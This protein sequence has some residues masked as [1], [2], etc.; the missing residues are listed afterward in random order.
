MSNTIDEGGYGT[1]FYLGKVLSVELAPE[2]AAASDAAAEE[3]LITSVRV[4]Y[5]MPYDGTR[6]RKATGC[7]EVPTMFCDDVQKPWKLACHGKHAWEKGCARRTAWQRRGTERWRRGVD[8]LSRGRPE[9]DLRGGSQAH[10]GRQALGH[11]EGAAR[12][13]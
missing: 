8:V 1:P 10:S 13:G 11:R 7:D 9:G 2:A 5:M 6:K 4:H 3:R 12:D